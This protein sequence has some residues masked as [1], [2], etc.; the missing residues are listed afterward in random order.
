MKRQS[1][2]KIM[3]RL[4]KELKPLVGV[5]MITITL[6]VL[7]F[8]TA[9]SIASFAA[10]ALGTLVEG[11][12][13]VSFKAAITIMAVCAVMRGLL[14]YGEQLSGHYIAF[15]ILY[16]LRDKIFAKLRTLAPAKLEGRDKGDLISLITSDIELLEV[17]YAHTIAPIA[18]A[19]LTNSMITALLWFIHP[20][21]GVLAA[22]FFILVGFVVPYAS[23]KLVS[24][25]GV[26]YRREFGSSNQYI[27]DS[28]RGLKEILLFN[29]GQERLTQLNQKSEE[30]NESIRK[31][32]DHEGIVTGITSTIITLAML[33]FLGV[34]A[35]L[36]SIGAVTLTLVLV[37]LV[38]IASS[39]G[40]VVALSNLSN[41]L[42]HTFACAERLFELLDEMPQ[43]EEV[44]GQMPLTMNEMTLDRV[45]FAYPNS[46]HL[47]LDEASIH[48]EKGEK[49]ALIGESGIGKSTFIKLLMRYFDTKKGH[50]FI[51]GTNIK[52]IPTASLRLKQTLVSQETYLFNDTIENNIKIGCKDASLEEVI[53]AAKKASI[54]EFIESLPK[55]YQTKVGELGG[56]VSSGEKQRLGLARAFLHNGDVLILDEPTSNL[57]ALN[58]GSILKS[59]Q[60]YGQDKTVILISHRKSTTAICEKVYRLENQK[61]YQN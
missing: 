20:I 15:K 2:F 55:G 9:I 24:E 43:V 14:R 52:S 49:L 38:V 40:P 45:S 44:S 17:F 12:T 1:G 42:A 19:I 48:I 34:G 57:D 58:E 28:L 47:L 54:H 23:S 5:M 3:M 37:A 11:A 61:L 7:G 32:K 39:F 31:I 51:D 8:L 30:L 35:Y 36:Y 26:N 6:G 56:M 59:I 18:I 60:D 25:A 4:L 53:E 33:V 50:V 16:L 13:I 10:V 46:D 21:Y 22:F 29:Q 41:T 27:L